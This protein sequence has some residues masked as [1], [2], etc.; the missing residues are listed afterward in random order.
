[1]KMVLIALLYIGGPMALT[2]LLYRLID[3]SGKK[4]KLLTDRFPILKEKKMMFQIFV[5]VILVL[6]FGLISIMFR[7]PVYVFF[8]VCGVVVGFINGMAVT[9]TYQD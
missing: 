8:I 3:H 1:M 2:Q 4:T 7:L 6:F 5:P 9:I